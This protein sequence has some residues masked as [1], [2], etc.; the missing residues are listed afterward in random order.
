MDNK[1]FTKMSRKLAMS[2]FIAI[3]AVFLM[4]FGPAAP[5]FADRHPPGG[6]GAPPGGGGGGVQRGPGHGGRF[7]AQAGLGQCRKRECAA[8]VTSAW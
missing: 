8:M 5:A 4:V 1:K 7:H 2:R 3:I 6:G